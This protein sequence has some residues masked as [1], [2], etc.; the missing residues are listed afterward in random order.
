MPTNRRE[1]IKQSVTAVGASLL[2]PKIFF[3]VARGQSPMPGTDRRVL[4]IV[5]LSGGNDG[6]N[7]VIPYA[8]SRYSALRPVIGFKD[9]DLKDPQGNSTIISNQLGLHPSM[10]KIKQLYD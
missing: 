1:F 10:G 3:S 8:D 6:L 2:V 5:E 4:V 7:T 9:S